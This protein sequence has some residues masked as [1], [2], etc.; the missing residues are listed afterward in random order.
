MSE[1]EIKDALSTISYIKNMMLPTDEINKMKILNRPGNEVFEEYQKFV[2]ATGAIDYDD[3]LVETYYLLINNQNVLGKYQEQYK[4]F[5]LDEAQDTS[6]L[7]F[8][9]IKLLASK[10]NNVFFVGDEDQSI[11]GFRAAYPEALLNFENEYNNAFIQRLET[12]YRSTAPIVNMAKKFIAKSDS[13]IPKAM[14]CVREGGRKPELIV[15]DTR[16]DQ[17]LKIVDSFEKTN[18]TIAVLFRE[19]SSAIPIINILVE[20]RIDFNMKKS[21]EV[22][23]FFYSKPVRDICSFMKV[24]KNPKDYDSYRE[25]AFKNPFNVGKSEHADMMLNK[26]KKDNLTVYQAMRNWLNYDKRDDGWIADCFEKKMNGCI[27]KK[28]SEIIEEILEMGY[29]AYLQKNSQSLDPIEILKILSM[30][31]NTIQEFFDH[32]KRLYDLINNHKN[33]D[34]EITLSTVHSAKGLE[35]DNVFIIDL[36]DGLFPKQLMDCYLEG[37][38]E[39]AEERRLF[40]VAMTRA[41]NE[42]TIGGIE[43][44]ESSYIDELF[45]CY[46]KSIKNV[47][48]SSTIDGLVITNLRTSKS[49]ILS[50][51]N[52]NNIKAYYIDV[53]TGEISEKDIWNEIKNSKQNI[54]EIYKR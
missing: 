42:L 32:L 24:I 36:Y 27:D 38:K 25:I 13:R 6:K 43:N 39:I 29:G 23:S 1:N 53:D 22:L 26:A 40:Y 52:I 37:Q 46:G 20:K 7:Q 33:K 44:R 31:N 11:Y 21:E 10:S 8:E 5:C 16:K 28:P 47:L 19:N 45:P 41:K 3:Q 15:V 2:R 48:C 30:E 50:A 49:Y 51:K 9:I 14:N 54:W 4:Y 18:G 35:F 12:N 17:Y 34:S